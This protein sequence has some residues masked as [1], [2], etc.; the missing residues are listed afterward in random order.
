M[1][2]FSINTLRMFDKN[3]LKPNRHWAER[4]RKRFQNELA[5]QKNGGKNQNTIICFL[6]PMTR[7]R[8]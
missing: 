4:L 7:M 8:I 6:I 1:L 3:L 5:T 2:Y